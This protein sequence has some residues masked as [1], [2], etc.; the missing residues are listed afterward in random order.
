MLMK[1]IE[2]QLNDLLV[3]KHKIFTTKRKEHS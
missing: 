1:T 2:K 3:P